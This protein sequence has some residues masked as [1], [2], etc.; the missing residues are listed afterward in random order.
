MVLYLPNILKQI[1]L[2]SDDEFINDIEE[3]PKEY[4]KG[5]AELGKHQAYDGIKDTESGMSDS[6]LT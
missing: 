1:E 2:S 4:L 3:D 6:N 5:D